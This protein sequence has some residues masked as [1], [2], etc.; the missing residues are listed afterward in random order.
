MEYK[1][2]IFFLFVITIISCKKSNQEKSD[3][4]LVAIKDG[5]YNILKYTEDFG[6]INWVSSQAMIFNNETLDPNGN[7]NADL[8]DISEDVDQSRVYQIISNLDDG[9]YAFSVHI[10]AL[11]GKHGKY[12]IGATFRGVGEKHQFRSHIAN[13]NDSVWTR[14]HVIIKKE[15]S[16]NMV[17]YPGYSKINGSE[18]KKAYIWGAQLEKLES[19]LSD[20]KPYKGSFVIK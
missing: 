11:P 5:G 14:A 6:D 12:T 2:I 7:P 15:G 16:G 19:Y 10:K 13:I 9:Y 3:K 18:I 20:I 17:V 8:I 4:N 1:K